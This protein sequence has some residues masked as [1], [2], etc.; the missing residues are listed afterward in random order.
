MTSPICSGVNSPSGLDVMA[1]GRPENRPTALWPSDVTAWQ[2]EHVVPFVAQR[3]RWAQM[4]Q[5]KVGFPQ[6][7]LTKG[8]VR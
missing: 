8:T 2:S 7:G 5:T 1:T 6:G 4:D 3:A